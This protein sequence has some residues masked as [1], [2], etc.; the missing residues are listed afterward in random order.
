MSTELNPAVDVRRK[1]A[2]V[3]LYPTIGRRLPGEPAWQ[4]A[5]QGRVMRPWA[6]NI[7]RRLVMQ[8]LRRTVRI[9]ENEMK[10]SILSERLADFWIRP[11][12]NHRIQIQLDGSEHILP[13]RS[14]S[15]GHFLS[16]LRVPFAM[17]RHGGDQAG[18]LVMTTARDNEGDSSATTARLI[19]PCGTTVIS[20]IDD[21]IKVSEVLDRRQM[22]RN[23]FLDTY[24]AVEGMAQTYRKW[25]EEGC[26][27]HYVSS[28]PWQ[29]FR[30]LDMFIQ[31]EGF[32]SGSYHLRTFRLRDPN[33]F[34]LKLAGTRSKRKAIRTLLKWYPFRQFVL[35]GDGGEK[36]AKLYAKV[37]LK[38]G[39]QI[40][41]IC[42]RRLPDPTGELERTVR[43]ALRDLPRSKWQLFEHGGELSHFQAGNSYGWNLQAE[44]A[45]RFA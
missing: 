17:A 19:P 13:K 27:F 24:R 8:L 39:H 16:P 7:Q 41:Q 40:A 35:I 31:E 11:C 15:S 18:N 9:T 21:T 25:A 32:P 5:V 2:S 38:H 29:L 44:S 28:S 37:A 45:G 14:R 10:S 42:I 30:P 23:A 22:F 6:D 4:V 26:E 43:H 12:R 3:E 34:Q 36:D 20:D 1:T 33:N